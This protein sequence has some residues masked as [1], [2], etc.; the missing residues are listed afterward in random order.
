M[1]SS[2][3][4]IWALNQDILGPF[5]T[6]FLT[7]VVIKW[8]MPFLSKKKNTAQVKL[9]NFY[10]V[11]YAFVKI[12][13]GFSVNIDGKIHNKVNCGYFHNFNFEVGKTTNVIYD[14][15]SF[16]EFTLGK[17]E[18]IDNDLQKLFIDYLKL[19]GPTNVQN[20]LGCEDKKLINFR[21]QIEKKIIFFY[22]KYQKD[23]I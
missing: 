15:N 9:S 14:E 17:F 6:I 7:I 1:S 13:E 19:R 21:K 16:F 23:L 5:L 12:R 11:A 3:L 20:K 4:Q 8:L 18:Y 22:K 2:Q 10:N